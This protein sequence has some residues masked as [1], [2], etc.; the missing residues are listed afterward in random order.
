MKI[1]AENDFRI[2]VPSDLDLWPLYLKFA[3][4][5]TLV[6]RYVSTKL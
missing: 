6:Q 5:A 1:W 4:L 3:L 2:L